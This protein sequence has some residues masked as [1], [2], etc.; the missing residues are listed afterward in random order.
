MAKFSVNNSSIIEVLRTWAGLLRGLTFG[1]NFKGYEWSGEIDAGETVKITHGLKVIPTRFIVLSSRL[2]NTIIK[3]ETAT[4]VD[5]IYL[6]NNA[7]TSTF[8]G[9]ILILP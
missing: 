6:K 7:S 3:S 4:T 2:V 5:F 9:K 1:E 8:T